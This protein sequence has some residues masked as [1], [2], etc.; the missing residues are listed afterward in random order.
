MWFN[1]VG[2]FFL[3]FFDKLI[4][5]LIKVFNIYFIYVLYIN[6]I[7]YVRRNLVLKYMKIW[8]FDKSLYYKRG[9]VLFAVCLGS[10]LCGILVRVWELYVLYLVDN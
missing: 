2:C 5:Y 3:K 4:I 9:F 6:I 1:R 7:I 10:F 8:Y